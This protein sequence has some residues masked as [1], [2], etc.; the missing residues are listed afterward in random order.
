MMNYRKAVLLLAAIPVLAVPLI[1]QHNE[2]HEGPEREFRADLRGRN[3]VPLTLSAARGT[4]ALTV[5]DADTS[6]HFVLE[7]S[8]LQT[9]VAASHIHVGQPN[10]NGGVT[11]F[12]CGG[13]GRPACP[14][15]AGTVEGDFTANDVL[16][17]ATQQLEVN[18]LAKLLR[19]IRAG[20]TYANVHTATSPGGEIR[21]QIHDDEKEH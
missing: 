7:Y 10:V 19:A 14:Q 1:A 21:G 5:N 12:F 16:P 18:N 3:E 6:V 13:G 11:V 15:A 20:K 8:G 4:L 17:L 9:T 2:R